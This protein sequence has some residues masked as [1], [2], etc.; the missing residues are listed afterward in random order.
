MIILEIS[1]PN[2]SNEELLSFLDTRSYKV[3]K[4]EPKAS[5]HLKSLRDI[6]IPYIP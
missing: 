4:S 1:T 2:K 5:E 3:K 6:I